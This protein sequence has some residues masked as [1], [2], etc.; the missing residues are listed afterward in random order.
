MKSISEFD[1]KVLGNTFIPNIFKIKIINKLSIEDIIFHQKKFCPNLGLLDGNYLLKLGLKYRKREILEYFKSFDVDDTVNFSVL[2][3]ILIIDEHL[4]NYIIKVLDISV[5]DKLISGNINSDETFKRICR[6]R[7]NDVYALINTA[8]KDNRYQ[9]YVSYC[10]PDRLKEYIIKKVDINYLILDLTSTNSTLTKTILKYR[11]K[12]IVEYVNLNSNNIPELENLLKM[13]LPKEVYKMLLEKFPIDNRMISYIFL[14]CSTDLKDLLFLLYPDKVYAW[15]DEFL[16]GDKHFDIIQLRYNKLTSYIVNKLNLEQLDDVIKGNLTIYYSDFINELF[17]VRKEDIISIITENV[18]LDNS[19]IIDYLSLKLPENILKSIMSCI[20]VNENILNIILKNGNSSVIENVFKIYKNE[21]LLIINKNSKTDRIAFLDKYLRQYAYPITLQIELLKDLTDEEIIY[22]MSQGVFGYALKDKIYELYKDR[23]NKIYSNLLLS[24]IEKATTIF[25]N[26]AITDFRSD[27]INNYDF[28]YLRYFLDEMNETEKEKLYKKFPRELKEMLRAEYSNDLLE[29][30]KRRVLDC[31]SVVLTLSL[32]L[33]TYDDIIFALKN[34]IDFKYYYN[35]KLNKLMESAIKNK[36]ND[37]KNSPYDECLI[38]LKSLREK[39]DDLFI[40]FL[41]SIELDD[42]FLHKLFIER[43]LSDKQ[44]DILFKMKCNDIL[45]IVKNKLL[46]DKVDPIEY[47]QKGTPDDVLELAL[48][49]IE[50]DRVINLLNDPNFINRK[51]IGKSFALKLAI[52]VN[53][54]KENVQEVENL[55]KY[56][57]KDIYEFINNYEKIYSFLK[58]SS[59]DVSKFWQYSLNTSYNFISDIVKIYED[60]LDMFLRVKDI[61]FTYVYDDNNKYSYQSFVNIIKNYSRYKK[62]CISLTEVE[63]LGAI[64]FNNIKL[65]FNQD[66][67]IPNINMYNDCGNIINVIKDEYMTMLKKCSSIDE[68]KDTLLQLLFN[69][70]IKSVEEMLNNYGKVSDLLQLKYYNLHNKEVLD[71]ID[72]V[73]PYTELMEEILYCD[74]INALKRTIDDTINNINSILV[75]F[76]YT[77]YD[78]LMRELYA[79]E[80]DMNLSKVGYNV[81]VDSVKLEEKSK[82]YGVDIYDFRDKQYALLAHVLSDS[83]NIDDLIQG[84]SSGTFNFISLSA[85]SHRMQSYYYG[86]KNMIFGYDEM[87]NSNFVCSSD[88]NMGTNYSITKNSTEMTPIN[89][90]QR[91]LLEVSD[92]DSNSEILSLRE[93]MKP[94][95]IICPGRLPSS[96]ELRCALKYNLKIVLTQE[97]NE[98]ILSPKPINKLVEPKPKVSKEYL[99]EFRNKVI[100]TGN[101]NKVAV[102]TDAH[103]ILEPTLAVL[104]DIRKKGITKIYSLG[105]NIGTGSNPSEVLDILNH[106]GVKSI[107]GNH[108]LYLIDGVDEYKKHLIETG[109]YEEETINTS[110]TRDNLTSEQVVDISKYDNYVEL[111]VAGNKVLLCHYLYDYNENKPLYDITKYDLVIQGHKHF[112]AQSGKVVTLKAI[113]IGNKSNDDIGSAT[114][115]IIDLNDK[116]HPYEII[117]VP[118]AYKNSINDENVSSNNCKQKIINWIGK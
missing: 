22:I 87:P 83:E 35:E 1:L 74:D 77:N 76:N 107:K 10:T 51:S 85:I 42:D 65:L 115:M 89:R 99:I 39:F 26:S 101:K 13:D 75:D 118:Y 2:K 3:S 117:N 55:V 5:I 29:F 54:N 100:K 66:K 116:E 105:D 84:N 59:I 21:L 43:G 27:I 69:H 40:V 12:D 92:T 98:T 106:Y 79:I 34:N 60:D 81:D 44:K 37:I 7:K 45:R 63:N 56:Y 82:L 46:N 17:K 102:I 72:C 67:L 61:L 52:I 97:I 104:E 110:W 111:D 96:E 30:I 36:A 91:G 50:K 93:G 90:K 64:N 6:L 94:K 41:N 16:I 70:N 19:K 33:L 15:V 53:V 68:Y 88:S 49:Y 71:K 78:D 38:F 114:Y 9:D 86:A 8:I 57:S 14:H 95:Y 73:I 112:Q 103:G 4:N 109:A 48:S 58:L 47:I 32:K 28:K 62:L 24:D 80:M 108:E 18:S 20:D 25:K 113:G 23:I 11:K 31:N